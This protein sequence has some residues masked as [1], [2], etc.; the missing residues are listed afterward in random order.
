MAEGVAALRFTFGYIH[1]SQRTRLQD[2]V[3]MPRTLCSEHQNN[4]TAEMHMY[5]FFLLVCVH[6]LQRVRISSIIACAQTAVCCEFTERV[7][8]LCYMKLRTGA[9][10]C[11]ARTLR[12]I[13]VRDR[14]GRRR[15]RSRRRRR[16]RGKCT[17]ANAA[18]RL[19]CVCDANYACKRTQ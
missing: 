19:D 2:Q 16:R 8:V 1:F 12:L 14:S 7:C 18:A 10:K 4:W 6:V 5:V 13:E 11:T 15:R 17:R 3:S 9:C